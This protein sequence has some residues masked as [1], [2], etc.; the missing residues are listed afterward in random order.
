[1]SRLSVSASLEAKILSALRAVAPS[2]PAVGLLEVASSGAAKV[3]D[4]TSLQVRVYNFKQRHAGTGLFSVSAEIRLNVEQAESAN[5]ALF[6]DTHERVA[7]WLE[8][9]MMDGACTALDTPSAC[10]DGLE[11]VGD[12][13]DFDISTGEWFALWNLTLSGRLNE[14]A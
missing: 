5:G 4:P 1:M 12:D 3:E 2:I 14:E 6:L 8:R 11:R 13:K 9:M 10:V 7:L